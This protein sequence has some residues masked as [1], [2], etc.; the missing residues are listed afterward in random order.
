MGIHMQNE[1]MGYIC[2]PMPHVHLTL[3][4][5]GKTGISEASFTYP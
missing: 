5:F 1:H 2:A 3:A 4:P